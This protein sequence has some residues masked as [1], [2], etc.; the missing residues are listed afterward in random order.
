MAIWASFGLEQFEFELT[1]YAHMTTGITVYGMIGAQT[2]FS[3]LRRG[4]ERHPPTS[5]SPRGRFH[6]DATDSIITRSVLHRHA[7]SACDDDL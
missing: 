5:I 1:E 6:G 4:Y 3:V 2:H 7:L